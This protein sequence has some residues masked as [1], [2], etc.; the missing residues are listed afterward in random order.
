MTLE[1]LKETVRSVLPQV[2]VVIG[3]RQGFDP[4]HAT[5]LFVTKPEQIEELIWNPLCVQNLASY[6]P[7]RKK[8][9]AVIVKGCDSRTIVQYLQETL[10]E[11]ENVVVIGIP[12]SGV[13][14]VSKV[15]TAIGDQP[16][17]GVSFEG[18]N[19]VV[20]TNRGEKKFSL[21]EVSPDKCRTCQY[22]TPLIY[23]HLVGDPIAS[24]KAPDSVFDEIREFEKKSLEERWVYWKQELGRCIRCYA[25]RNACPMCVCQDRCI[26]ESRDPHW[27]SQRVNETERFMFHF[28]H[29]LHLAGRCVECEECSRVCPME[30]PLA[31]IKKKINMEMKALFDYVP[32][33]NPED[34]PPMY[35]FKVEEAHIEEHEL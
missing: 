30:I 21:G 20:K 10:I 26:A 15:M 5:P 18:G 11:R 32:G 2:D 6:L 34:K 13:V 19:V 25:C 24:D 4:L 29:A 3:Y 17:T 12:C 1:K 27:M 7:S 9:T 23:D 8:K 16:V 28:I 14:S 22:P 35:T 31:K 33:V